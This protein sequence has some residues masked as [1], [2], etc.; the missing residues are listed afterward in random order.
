M[1]ETIGPEE[2]KKRIDRGDH[3]RL[4]AVEPEA[5][6]REAHLPGAVRLPPDSMRDELPALLPDP[7]EAIVLY[8]PDAD[9]PDCPRAAAI[10]DEAGYASV[11]L[12]EGGKAAWRD[13]G[14][15]LES[16]EGSG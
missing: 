2:L 4:V 10:L 11:A 12:F 6:Y 14:Y 16:E 13:A 1:S 8:G 7:G 15:P 9:C 3:F 5:T